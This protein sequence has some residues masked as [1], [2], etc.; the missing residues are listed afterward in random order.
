MLKR[1]QVATEYLIL[2]A[3]AILIAIVVV[4]VI[5]GVPGVGSGTNEQQSRLALLT[6][7]VGVI[8]Y[9]VGTEFTTLTIRNNGAQAISV[10]QIVIDGIV[11]DG[12]PDADGECTILP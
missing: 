11:C 3:V 10:S 5:G 12:V 6:A 7:D 9:A 8:S 2:G 1:S 4:V